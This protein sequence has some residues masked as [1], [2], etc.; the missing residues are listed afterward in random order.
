MRD[1]TIAAFSGFHT[2][3]V[4]QKGD[5]NAKPRK[6]DTNIAGDGALVFHPQALSECRATAKRNI[7]I[8][9]NFDCKRDTI[10][11]S[12][13]GLSLATEAFERC[14]LRSESCQLLLRSGHNSLTVLDHHP[15]PTHSLPRVL[16][17][18]FFYFFVGI[19]GV[20]SENMVS[21][22]KKKCCYYMKY[23]RTNSFQS[24]F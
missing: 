10:S 3:R 19:P 23:Q 13:G 5:W 20:Q 15:A 14:W 16:F 1:Q 18:S 7:L 8:L 6:L 11:G 12:A 4:V 17:F 24:R 22:H 9:A 2:K 21:W